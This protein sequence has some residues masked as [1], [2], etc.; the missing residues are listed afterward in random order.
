MALLG[1]S[2]LVDQLKTSTENMQKVRQRKET[3]R[4][5]ERQQEAEPRPTT[6]VDLTRA[7]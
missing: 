2:E 5:T 1:K 4:A 6:P 7:T 3:E